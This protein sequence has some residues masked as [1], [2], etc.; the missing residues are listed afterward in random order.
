VALKTVAH[1]FQQKI[2]DF[3]SDGFTAATELNFNVLSLQNT[4]QCSTIHCTAV[5][6]FKLLFICTKTLTKIIRPIKTQKKAYASANVLW[7]VTVLNFPGLDYYAYMYSCMD[8]L[9][10]IKVSG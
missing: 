9:L 2:G 7:K 1:L 10:E 4:I 6:Q 3:S 5:N 8:V